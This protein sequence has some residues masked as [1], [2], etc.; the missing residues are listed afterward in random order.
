MLS[1]EELGI[2]TIGFSL[3]SFPQM[4][5]VVILMLPLAVLAVHATPIIGSLYDPRYAAAAGVLCALA[6]NRDAIAALASFGARA[7]APSHHIFA[8]ASFRVD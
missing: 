1:L 4:L 8:V 7:A 2:Y 6:A 5:G 3:A